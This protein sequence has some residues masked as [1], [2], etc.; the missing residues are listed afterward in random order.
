MFPWRRI[1]VPTDFSTA[2]E[3]VFSD[4]VR[5]AAA[6][7]AEILILHIR[8]T[9]RSEPSQL[10]FPADS[11]LYEY[12]ERHELELLE[13]RAR[14][15]HASVTTRLVVRQAPE[16]GEEI[17]RVAVDE[18]VDLIVI[19]THARHHVAHLLLGS[20]TLSVLNDPPAPVLA[21]RYGTRKRSGFHR[22]VVPVHLRQPTHPAVELAAAIAARDNGEVHLLS[23][24]SN[25]EKSEAE[26]LLGRLTQTIAAGVNTKCT[27]TS[28]TDVEHE[29]V[30]YAE[31]SD[32]DAVFLNARSELS[33]KKVDIV[34]HLATPVMIVP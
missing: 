7:A 4:A 8:M 17:R 9:W 18:N 34:R 23:V 26:N 24:C 16:A 30:R 11:S 21:I 13:E 29:I 33:E 19:A 28:G 3:W 2:A 27:I 20:T 10:R 22:I 31:T 25:E 32:A 1:L 5:I 6:S 14:R 12:A 15:Q